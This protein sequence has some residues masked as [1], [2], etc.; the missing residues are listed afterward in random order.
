[1]VQTSPYKDS[2]HAGTPAPM[3]Y[4]L[5]GWA[6]SF[7]GIAL[8]LV[9]EINVTVLRRFKRRRGLYFWSLLATSWGISGH[10]LGYI[11]AWWV[12]GSPW[13]FNTACILFGWSMMVTGQSL[14]LYSR[15]HLVIRN[16]DI[17]R[18]SFFIM[19]VTFFAIEIPGWVTT[20]P[21]T[22]PKVTEEWSYRDSIMVRVTQLAF[23]ILESYLC[24]LYILGKH[25]DCLHTSQRF[26]PEAPGKAFLMLETDLV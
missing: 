4:A 17:L 8:F 2:L 24:I 26:S 21:A 1:M 14:V 20:W 7:F 25:Q 3:P 22:D 9:A 13:I 6:A 18:A 12:P 15:L 11:F 19:I 16:R 5:F 10:T 23:P